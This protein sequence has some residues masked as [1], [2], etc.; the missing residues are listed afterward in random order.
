ML[1]STDESES[2]HNQWWVRTVLKSASGLLFA[3][4]LVGPGY[5]LLPLSSLQVGVIALVLFAIYLRLEMNRKS[6]TMP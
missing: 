5:A 4:A 6:R 2:Q 3:L 1:A